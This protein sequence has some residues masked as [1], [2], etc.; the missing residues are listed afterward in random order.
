MNIWICL[1]FMNAT[2]HT[3][4]LPCSPNL[5]QTLRGF[6]TRVCLPRYCRWIFFLQFVNLKSHLL[7]FTFGPRDFTISANPTSTDLDPDNENWRGH[8]YVLLFSVFSAVVLSCF[9]FLNVLSL[10]RNFRFFKFNKFV[11]DL[12]ISLHLLLL[13]WTTSFFLLKK[14]I[15]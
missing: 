5:T 4:D 3:G 14:G 11:I 8:F 12:I 9:F 10:R 2:D 15:C 13:S 7:V 6:K 1:Y